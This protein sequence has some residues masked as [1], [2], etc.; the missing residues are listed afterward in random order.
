MAQKQRRVFLQV[1]RIEPKQLL[2]SSVIGGFAQTPIL[3]M[4]TYNSTLAGVKNAFGTVAKTHD[5]SRLA[6]SLATLS[7]RLPYGQQL[8]SQWINDQSI[9]DANNPGSGLAMQHKLL[10]DTVTYVQ[11]GATE[12]LFRVIGSGSSVFYSDVPGVPLPRN[13]TIPTELV[14]SDSPPASY[15]WAT[16]ATVT[17]FTNQDLPYPDVWVSAIAP[18]PKNPSEQPYSVYFDPMMYNTCSYII[19]L[20]YYTA[21]P[22]DPPLPYEL[23]ING[24]VLKMYPKSNIANPKTFM[25]DLNSRMG[26]QYKLEYKIESGNKVYY[27]DPV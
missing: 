25:D 24:Q 3:T 22:K 9:Y 27:L 12:G 21:K 4:S 18:G 20:K 11:S 7:A 19:Y 10:S 17:N 1:E 8:L 16:V 13:K 23:H 5:F 26:P 14:N 15:A 2:S 6:A